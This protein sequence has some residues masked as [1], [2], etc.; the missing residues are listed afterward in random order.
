MQLCDSDQ[1]ACSS[2]LMF[3]STVSHLANKLQVDVSFTRVSLL[4]ST[5][6][7]AQDVGNNL[8]QR[9]RYISTLFQNL[10]VNL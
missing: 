9:I 7:F 6:V 3:E 10:D 8:H 1:N 5:T 4:R 2:P